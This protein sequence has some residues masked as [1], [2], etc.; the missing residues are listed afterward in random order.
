M[1]P[2]EHYFT[3]NYQVDIHYLKALVYNLKS[4]VLLLTR[5]TN[6]LELYTNLS[7]IL[8]DK[9]YRYTL[10]HNFHKNRRS[11]SKHG[12]SKS[13]NNAGILV[14]QGTRIRM[15]CCETLKHHVLTL[16]EKWNKTRRD[17]RIEEYRLQGCGAV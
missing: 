17:I 3:F 2:P 12:G 8:T 9:A 5:K 4:F 15:H 6:C 7:Y 11:Y 1:G 16:G 13:L 14:S 10:K